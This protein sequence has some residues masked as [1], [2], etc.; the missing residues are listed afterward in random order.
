[1]T[2]PNEH[3]GV[4]YSRDKKAEAGGRPFTSIQR[5]GLNNVEFYLH[6]EYDFITGLIK[7]RSNFTLRGRHWESWKCVRSI[8][9]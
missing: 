2:L 9:F 8:R 6:F 5:R 4:F 7:H 1:M 3:A